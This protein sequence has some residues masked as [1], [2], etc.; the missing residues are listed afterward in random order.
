MC[1]SVEF[2]YVTLQCHLSE[3]DRRSPGAFPIDLVDTQGV[4]YFENACLQCKYQTCIK[5]VSNILPTSRKPTFFRLLALL[6]QVSFLTIISIVFSCPFSL[7]LSLFLPFLLSLNSLYLLSLFFPPKFYVNYSW[8]IIV[9]PTRKKGR[10]KVGKRK[11]K[12][13]KVP[14]KQMIQ[15]SNFVSL[16]R[17]KC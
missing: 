15:S 13:E 6:I 10:K 5:L 17:L 11:E 12:S 9:C 1:R 3:Y 8:K 14:G 2:N 7:F 16:E 4:D